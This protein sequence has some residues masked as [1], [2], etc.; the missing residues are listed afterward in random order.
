MNAHY[1][2]GTTQGRAHLRFD[3]RRGI[4]IALAIRSVEEISIALVIHSL[5]PT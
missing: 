2:L 1:N 4:P 3:G 5:D